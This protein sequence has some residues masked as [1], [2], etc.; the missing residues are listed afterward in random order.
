MIDEVHGVKGPSVAA[1]VPETARRPMETA[2]A[3]AGP[4][5]PCM[6]NMRAK[7]HR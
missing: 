4:H 7:R 6:P 3:R 1:P 2:P 5:R